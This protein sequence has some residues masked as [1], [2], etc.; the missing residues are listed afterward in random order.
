MDAGVR[1]GVRRSALQGLLPHDRER[2][3]WS[4]VVSADPFDLELDPLKRDHYGRPLL[5]PA[6]GTERVPYTRMSTLS[7]YLTDDFGLGLWTQRLLA[8]GMSYREDLCAMAASLPPLNDAKRDKKSLSKAEIAQDRD[9]K[10]KIDE[11]IEQALESAGR[12]Y[13]AN[14]GTS[15]HSFVERGT[16][17]LAPERI[18][19]DIDSCFAEFARHGIEILCSELFVANDSLMAAGSF[20]H[21]VR[22]PEYGVIGADV[23]TGQVDGK[24][25]AF[26]TQVA[27][28][29]GGDLY[30][31]ETDRRQPLE[32]ATGGEQIN[33]DVG[34]LIHIPLGGGRTTFYK[35]DLTR[36]FERLAT[37]VRTARS[38]KDVMTP[39][40]SLTSQMTG[41]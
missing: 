20:D 13:K 4:A 11:Y 21:I 36:G 24:G 25:L 39:C 8:L 10:S 9:T 23:K 6:G 1:R 7:G 18:K 12:N 28:Y 2:R 27:G 33:R 14:M 3:F 38:T 41:A 30:D 17:D 34:L 31:P 29:M 16:S 40:A 26:C 15:I 37:H 5:I 22:H 19:P 35:L 32:A